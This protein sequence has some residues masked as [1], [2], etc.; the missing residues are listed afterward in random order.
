[1]CNVSAEEQGTQN[2]LITLL[3]LLSVCAMPSHLL[4]SY[5]HMIL[6]WLGQE[7]ANQ[8]K[9]YPDRLA[10]EE[11]SEGRADSWENKTLLNDRVKRKKTRM[12]IFSILS[13][14]L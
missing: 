5:P 10:K 3:S 8:P 2:S 7:A 11:H 14:V 4:V 13:D 9:D 6:L 1:M 12:T